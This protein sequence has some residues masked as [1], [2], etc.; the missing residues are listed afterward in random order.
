MEARTIILEGTCNFRDFGGYPAAGGALVKRGLL[1]RS[2][3]LSRLAPRAFERFAALGIRTLVDLRTEDERLYR[4]NSLPPG[5]NPRAVELPMSNSPRL[6]KRWTALEKAW[7]MLSG[8]MQR[9]D[10][11]FTVEMYR[12][13]PR[14]NERAIAGLFRALLVPGAFPALV[15]C[16]AGRDRTGFAAAMILRA[17]G[18]PAQDVLADYCLLEDGAASVRER[19]VRNMRAL[20]LYR[21][22]AEA[23]REFFT[24]QPEYLEAAF[25]AIEREHGSVENYLRDRAGLADADRDALRAALLEE[26]P[27]HTA[28]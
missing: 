10:R 18:V 11:R 5:A 9:V 24:P 19:F 4:P 15:M 12:G 6:D 27:C 21:V 16:S 8:G 23:I 14:R 26:A 7:F 22:R 1:Y 13:M 3:N 20:S 2:D 25:E 17:L 28:S